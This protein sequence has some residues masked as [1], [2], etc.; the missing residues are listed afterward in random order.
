MLVVSNWHSTIFKVF[1]SLTNL[2]LYH[3]FFT[4]SPLWHSQRI[5][6]N[7]AIIFKQ[8]PT[9]ILSWINSN[10][11]HREFPAIIKGFPNCESTHRTTKHLSNID[12]SYINLIKNMN[13]MISITVIK[14]VVY[15]CLCSFTEKEQSAFFRALTFVSYR[16]H[17]FRGLKKWRNNCLKAKAV[18][19]ERTKCIEIPSKSSKYKLVKSHEFLVFLL[20]ALVV[21]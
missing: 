6:T 21:N 19:S 8:N 1:T 11:W 5:C 3:F 13:T 16:Q 9:R 14:T 17:S 7:V 2:W 15:I 18:I 12:D 4:T 20:S 10:N